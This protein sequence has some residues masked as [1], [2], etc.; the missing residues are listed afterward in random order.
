MPYQTEVLPELGC[1]V[2]R[3]TGVIG[4]EEMI[5]EVRLWTEAI[6][7]DERVRTLMIDHSE[8]DLSAIGVEEVK[9]VASGSARLYE[10]APDLY[11]VA[12][13]GRNL[14]FALGR[15]WQAWAD[16]DDRATIARSL[17]H[18]EE[19]LARRGIVLD[20]AGGSPPG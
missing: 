5:A 2:S 15:M 17:E 18:A 1:I 7:S 12:I 4:T 16:A 20:L 14:G 8:A 10:A 9:E 11:T 19:I 3:V 13:Y 6:L